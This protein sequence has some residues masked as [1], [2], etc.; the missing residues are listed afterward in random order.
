MEPNFM[1]LNGSNVPVNP[2]FSARKHLK[3]DVVA[4]VAKQLKRPSTIFS[5]EDV[6]TLKRQQ[7]KEL[8]CSHLNIVTERDEMFRH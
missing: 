2:V 7:Q 5:L 3:A 6:G 8:T 1:K 4:S